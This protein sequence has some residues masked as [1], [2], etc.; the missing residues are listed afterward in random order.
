MT[1][2]LKARLK[3]A[4]SNTVSKKL[5]KDEEEDL[6]KQEYLKM[7]GNQ[8]QCG[9]SYDVIPQF[10]KVL[11]GEEDFLQQKLREE[12]RAQFLQRKSKLLL[13]NAELKELWVI[14]DSHTSGA[15]VGEDQMMDW[16][17][18]CVVRSLVSDKCR[19]YFKSQ[20]FSKL[21][22]GDR[23]GRISIMALFNYVMR[24]VWLHQT[25]IGLSLYDVT[26]QGYLRE[27]DLENY[28][29]E[30]IETLPQ[31]D[32][33][34][35]SFHPFYVCTAVR[36]FFFFLD[37]LRVGK[38]KIQDVLACSFL[39]DLLELRDQELSKEH[40]EKN[41]FSAP[42]ALRVYGQYLNLDADHNGMLSMNELGKY[43]TG[44]L[45]KVF[46]E[47]VFQECLTYDGEMDYKTYL[48]FV[49]AMENKSD[50]QSLQY[51]FRIL[52][53]RHEGYLSVY[54][55]NFF[56]RAIQEEMKG[57]GQEPVIFEDVKDEIFDMVA[58]LDPLKIKLTDLIRSGQGETV[59]QILTDLN[60]FWSY[61]NRE[62]LAADNVDSGHG[63]QE[64]G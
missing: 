26:G 52:D 40:Q 29:L 11:P 16:D 54:S 1:E 61:E 41:W 56:F 3:A 13:D 23:L 25:R 31:L 24:K 44:T 36:K 14:L 15:Q 46:I 6:F 49:L 8:H 32:G 20:V 47:R 51:L 48:D 59:V 34:E 7:K 63:D 19:E 57:H 28:I 45:T 53:T 37:P 21:Q 55:I 42:S 64:E 18:Y 22:Q 17:Q 4:N 30:L 35:K 43:G 58:P 33:L 27:S 10:H 9:N 62:V 2:I 38:I 39:D 50:P 60:G 5:S 12:A